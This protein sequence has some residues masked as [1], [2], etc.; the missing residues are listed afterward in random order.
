MVAWGFMHQRLVNGNVEFKRFVLQLKLQT[1][2]QS[3]VTLARGI[4]QLLDYAKPVLIGSGTQPA[5]VGA[6][7]LL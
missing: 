5:F 2:E 3:K 4:T 6:P 1:L 7:N